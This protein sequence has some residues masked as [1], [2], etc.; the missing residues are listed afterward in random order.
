L[1]Y[2]EQARALSLK[3]R[4]K[5]G[6]ARAYNSLGVNYWAKHNYIKAQECYLESLRINQSLND[7]REMAR[8]I[9]NIADI[10][11]L[12]YDYPQALSYYFR[13]LKLSQSAGDKF[14]V[15]GTESNIADVYKEEKKI[16]EAIYFQKRAIE[17]AQHGR[18]TRYGASLVVG[19]GDLESD[20][21]D[22]KG[23]I[24]H[25]TD[26]LHL[27]ETIAAKNPIKD[28]IANVFGNLGEIYFKQTDYKNSIFYY[29]R[30]YSSYKKIA[31]I[32]TQ[33]K[34]CECLERVGRACFQL[35]V[36]YNN[37]EDTD[38]SY[39]NRQ[40]LENASNKINKAITGLKK[41][42][43]WG[44]LE[45]SFFYLSK[46]LE[47][48]K[49]YEA[50]LNAYKQYTAY[51]DSDSNNEKD[52][53]I[54]VKTVEYEYG[55]QKDSL[56]NVNKLQ[57]AR[58][59]TL[60]QEKE[61]SKLRSKQQW[62]YIVGVALAF[63]S[64]ALFIVYRS[65]AKQTRLENQLVKER[66]EYQL[67]E[68]TQRNRL[69]QATLTALISQMNPHFIFNA[70]NTIQSYIYTNNKS[71][72]GH[73][74]G[75]FSELTRKILDNS[76]KEIISL[77]DEI[78]MLQLYIDIEKARFGDTFN[79]SVVIDPAL[80]SEDIFLPPMLIQP[81]VE[82]AIKHGLLHK[83]G[84]RELLISIKRHNSDD[85][86]IEIVI[87]DNGI[88]RPQSM[89]LNNHNKAHRSFATTAT[90]KRI[91][92]INR[93]LGQKIKLEIIDKTNGDGGAEGTRVL[94]VISVVNELS[95]VDIY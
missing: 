82:N 90:E 53:E 57:N 20:E 38:K 28:D 94:L 46:V 13:A 93:I 11:S 16:P 62:F 23:A 8:N 84:D 39:K 78:E 17:I 67:G 68:A 48:Q 43:D 83:K 77:E 5:K 41:Y 56:G 88:G 85:K 15:C 87:D 71:S 30:A 49:K 33:T 74:L 27:F 14:G 92:L 32:W 3:L 1:Y 37:E 9:H 31:G 80:D 72:A 45:Q 86:D 61:L 52:K 47:N 22:F 73:Y 19:L 91:E 55:R 35:A 7:K 51:K 40:C 69:I 6:E 64:T 21:G 42:K 81:H 59:K 18:W 34:S 36:S 76:S 26:A 89:L 44:G 75:K 24:L 29:S 25:E 95:K 66:A 63:L 65:R 58:L 50:S 2:G 79:A 4:W 70:L 54:A 60:V 10:Y 12:Q